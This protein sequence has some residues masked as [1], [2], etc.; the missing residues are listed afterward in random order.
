MSLQV[1]FFRAW[2]GEVILVLL[3]TLH[4]MSALDRGCGPSF[5]SNTGG[6]VTPPAGEGQNW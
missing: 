4:N 6:E 3:F 2:G 5:S 1:L